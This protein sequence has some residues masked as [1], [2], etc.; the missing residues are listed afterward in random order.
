MYLNFFTMKESGGSLRIKVVCMWP[1]IYNE[2]DIF[3]DLGC[4]EICDIAFEKYVIIQL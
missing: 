1:M 3:G 4:T 2:F